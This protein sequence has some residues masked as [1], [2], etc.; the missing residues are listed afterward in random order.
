MD[1]KGMIEDW[2]RAHFYDGLYHADSECACKI[3]DLAPCGELSDGACEP[4]YKANCTE[5]C[6][7]ADPAVWHIQRDKPKE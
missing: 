7:H 2:L 1:V 5:D 3:D 4:G 6:R